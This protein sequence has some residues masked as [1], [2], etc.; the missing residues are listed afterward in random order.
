MTSIKYTIKLV[1]DAETSSGLGTDL[2]DGLVARNVDGNPVI[3]ASHI[4]GLMRQVVKN[5]P[6][7]FVAGTQKAAL[8]KIFGAA[9]ANLENGSLFSVTDGVSECAFTRLITRTALDE[10]GVAKNGSLRTNEAISAGSEFNGC[11]HLLSENEV[12]DLLVRY[13]LLSVFEIGGSRNRGAGACVVTI[14]GENRTP[15]KILQEL[16]KADY[17]SIS[18]SVAEK[19]DAMGSKNVVYTKLTFVA[20]SPLCLPELPI[21]GNNTICSGFTIPASAVQGCVLTKINAL[22]E[23]IAT[24]TFESNFFRT[25]PLLPIPMN[26]EFEDCF[27]VRA[28]A[29]HKISKLANENDEYNF[30][31]ET[32]EPYAWAERPENAP[33]KSADGVLIAGAKSGVVLWRSG[34][35]ARHLSAHGVVNGGA[36]G[37]EDSL[38]TVES[39]AEK[40]FVGFMAIP[41][42]AFNLLQKALKK[43]PMV[44]MGKARTVRGLGELSVEKISSLPVNLP[45]AKNGQE[46][47]AF[48]VQS[49]ILIDSSIES[50]S[51]DEILKIMV[52]KAGWGTVEKTSANLQILFGWNRH[53]NG[54]QQAQRVIAAGSVFSLSAKPD[55]LNA[56]LVEGIG[57]EKERGF[58]AVLPHPN[59][60]CRRYVPLPAR[61][62]AKSKNDA[63]KIGWSLWMKSSQSGSPL[64][65]SQIGQLH[66]VITASKSEAKAY[67]EKQMMR[68]DHIWVRWRD[69]VEDVEKLLDCEMDYINAALTVWHDLRV[70]EEA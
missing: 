7:T 27:A 42:D 26:E 30:C 45:R 56:K 19:V 37:D 39:L 63:A 29:S 28:S 34:D 48:I 61:K 41:E 38:Y 65:A 23:S 2:V 13:T 52:E 50:Q 59:I 58:G 9:G 57:G 53:K 10:R 12:V 60:A 70:A 3:P 69:I 51:A 55:D 32:I 21:V 47:N 25:W 22:N 6:E 14:E 62:N 43:D 15:G 44:S 31:D 35:M 5:L 54:L 1:S 8:L 16:V 11:V 18:L 64:S 4:K 36:S 68:P 46:V 49:P 40:K 33:I 20:K 66:S 67:L 17:N 24:Q